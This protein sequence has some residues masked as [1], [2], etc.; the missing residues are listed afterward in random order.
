MNVI[1]EKIKFLIFII[2]EYFKNIVEFKM[3][4][5]DYIHKFNKI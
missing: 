5:K 3:F 2:V 1:I 4:D